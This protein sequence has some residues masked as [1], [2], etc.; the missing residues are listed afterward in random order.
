MLWLD[1]GCKINKKLKLLKI[2]LGTKGFY[3]S[4]VGKINQWTSKESMNN[5]NFPKKYINKKNYA[6]GMVG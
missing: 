2:I 5:L 3:V 4:S 6:S 1:A